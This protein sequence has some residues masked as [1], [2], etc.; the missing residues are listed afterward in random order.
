MLARRA[1]RASQQQEV[2]LN[3]SESRASNPRGYTDPVRSAKLPTGVNKIVTRF[4]GR[5]AMGVLDG[6]VAIITGGS[7]GELRNTFD[8]HMRRE[9]LIANSCRKP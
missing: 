3:V 2:A 9:A 7:S 1:T 4:G 8:V 5:G 6:K